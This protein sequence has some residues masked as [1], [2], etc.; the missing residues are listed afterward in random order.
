M[1]YRELDQIAGEIGEA[2]ENRRS[3]RE[4][5]EAQVNVYRLAEREASREFREARYVP[6]GASIKEGLF[7]RHVYANPRLA[8]DI[9]IGLHTTARLRE[10]HLSRPD[11]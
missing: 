9:V 8:E 5:A 4:A 1:T 6:T 3:D 7:V 11:D 10:R 2:L